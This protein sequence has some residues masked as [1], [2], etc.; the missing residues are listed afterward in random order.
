MNT[1]LP[2]ARYRFTAR[3]TDDLRLPAYA[4]SLLRGVF[5]AA[6]R[7]TA[8]MTGLPVCSECPLW[9]TCAYPAVFETP[10]Q[11]TQFAQRFTQVPNPYVVEPPA[12]TDG[13]QVLSA[14]EPLVWHMVL[15]GEATLGRL[16]LV[17]HAWQR[18]LDQG[19]GTERV[20]GALLSVDLV[21][22]T[23]VLVPVFEA[24][25]A[26]VLPHEAVL[27]LAPQGA[28]TGTAEVTLHFHTPLRLQHQGQVLHPGQ[29][30]A[31]T[32]LSQMLRRTN[33]ML[34]LHLGVRPAPFDAS[35]LLAA[36]LPTLTDDRRA[37]RWR[38]WPRYSGRQQQEM[39]LGGVMGAWTLRADRE[40]LGPFLPWLRLGQW[41]HLGKN[42]TMGLGGYQLQVHAA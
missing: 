27:A 14:G 16:A 2:I 21:G 10:P 41:L 34:D 36:V 25:T 37:L 22:E 32:L 20:P 8:C 40:V 1:V 31:R 42:A 9:R 28:D 5:G 11:P 4:G 13:R 39:N 35:A 15:A 26:R 29:L 38:D 23:G 24:D 33:L 6:L 3:F 17:V 19:L 18:A 7:R 12:S 30:D